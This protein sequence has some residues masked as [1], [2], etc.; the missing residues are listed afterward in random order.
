MTSYFAGI[1]DFIGGHP[2]Y[3]LTAIFLLALSEAIPVIGTIVPGS[4]LIIGI[5]ALASS[6]H[7]NPW[8]LLRCCDRGSHFRRWLVLLVRTPLPSGDSPVLAA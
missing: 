4:T 3:A 8:F 5:C 1:V 6:A 7:L 2:Y